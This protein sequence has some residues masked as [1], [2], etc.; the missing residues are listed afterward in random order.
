MLLGKETQSWTWVQPAVV[1]WVASKSP[2][3]AA[4]LDDD[5][6]EKVL[7]AHVGK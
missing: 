6:A 1:A 4:K 3:L 2:S 5:A 7:L